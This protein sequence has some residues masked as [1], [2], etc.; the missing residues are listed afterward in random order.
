MPRITKKELENFMLDNPGMTEADA[1][2]VLWNQ[3]V[4]EQ[5]HSNPH[6]KQS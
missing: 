2:K 3:K 1:R 4:K 6:W 5:L